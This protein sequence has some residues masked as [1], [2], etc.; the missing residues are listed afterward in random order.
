MPVTHP[1]RVR[2]VGL[3]VHPLCGILQSCPGRHYGEIRR[4]LRK[5]TDATSITASGNLRNEIIR[6]HSKKTTK[7]VEY[8]AGGLEGAT[9]MPPSE[10]YR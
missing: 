7:A 10:P 2:N 9:A 5:M 3:E 4:K 6:E 8:L 1:K